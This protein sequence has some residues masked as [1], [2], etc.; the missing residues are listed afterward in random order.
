MN[1]DDCAQPRR[2]V[3]P[4]HDELVPVEFAPVEYFHQ[5]PLRRCDLH[6]TGRLRARPQEVV[7]KAALGAAE[8]KYILHVGLQNGTNHAEHTSRPG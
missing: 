4:E 2:R 5:A 3:V 1:S 8:M 6:T 7:T